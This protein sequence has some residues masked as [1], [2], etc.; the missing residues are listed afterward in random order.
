MSGRE[1][2]KLSDALIEYFTANELFWHE[3]DAGCV[4]CGQEYVTISDHRCADCT[5]QP[6]RHCMHCLGDIEGLVNR[7]FARR[8]RGM[9]IDISEAFRERN[10]ARRIDEARRA[11]EY[12]QQRGRVTP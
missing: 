12:R 1:P 10:T 7:D 11:V 3:K 2:V 5:G 4:S 6:V 8:L 9:S